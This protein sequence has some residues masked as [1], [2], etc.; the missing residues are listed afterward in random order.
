M[1]ISSE[2]ARKRISSNKLF[3]ECESKL[4]NHASYKILSIEYKDKRRKCKQIKVI[5][6]N[7]ENN[8]K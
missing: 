8:R 4:T 7:P 2:G 5:E 6:S 3:P 1:M